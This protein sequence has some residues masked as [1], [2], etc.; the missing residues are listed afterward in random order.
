MRA[1]WFLCASLALAL[2]GCGGGE[3]GEPQVTYATLELSAAISPD[4]P[5]V[6]RHTMRIEVRDAQG[7]PVSGAKVTVVP[8]MPAHGH[9]S[10]EQ[11]AVTEEGEGSYLAHPVTFQM[12]G[13][14]EVQLLA[15]TDT[16]RGKRVLRFDVP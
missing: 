6:G 7:A 11:P 14:W 13:G 12:P 5:G 9:G 15:S 3:A 8:S 2:P 1:R 16:A 10:T 4:P